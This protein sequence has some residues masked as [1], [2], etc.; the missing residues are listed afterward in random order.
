MSVSL[1]GIAPHFNTVARQAQRYAD[2]VKENRFNRV[3]FSN[4]DKP[5]ADHVSF[6]V[7]I[8]ISKDQMS[9]NAPDRSVNDVIQNAATNAPD[10]VGT[11]PAA[12]ST[13]PAPGV[14]SSSVKSVPPKK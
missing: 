2:E 11:V 7:D 8:D 13:V 5:S 12:T 1:I 6:K 10:S 4:L 14:A 3:I 9:Y